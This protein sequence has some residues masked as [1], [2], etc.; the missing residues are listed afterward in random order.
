MSSTIGVVLMV[1]VTVILAAAVGTFALGLAEESTKETPSAS[2][3]VKWGTVGSDDTV[4]ITIVGGDSVKSRFVTVVHQ[5][6]TELWADGTTTDVSP[7]G[8][9]TWSGDEI[10]SGDTLGLQE[11][12]SDIFQSDDTVKVIWNNGQKSQVLGSGTLN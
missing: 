1:A 12:S 6:G 3:E 11:D 8:G 2:V 5:D 7:Y 10:Q 9:K 4:D